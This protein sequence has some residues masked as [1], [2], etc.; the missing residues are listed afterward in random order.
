MQYFTRNILVLHFFKINATWYYIK[1]LNTLWPLSNQLEK[2]VI[3]ELFFLHR[4]ASSLVFLY[5]SIFISPLHPTVSAC[6][7]PSPSLHLSL[8]LSLSACSVL[9][10]LLTDSH[11]PMA[12]ACCSTACV[13]D[14]LSPASQLFIS[15]S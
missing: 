7:F 2:T 6:V 9:P 10:V 3:L 13:C 8:S 4:S 11:V 15:S 1:S 5:I 12:S 14:Q